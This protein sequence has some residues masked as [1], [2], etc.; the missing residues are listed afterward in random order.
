MILPRLASLNV[1]LAGLA[2]LAVGAATYAASGSPHAS[3]V[4][5]PLALLALNLVAA[6]A[7]NGVFRRDLPLMLFH[8]ALLAIVVLAGVGRL[9]HFQG[10]A[11]LAEG[12]VFEG[13][14]TVVESGPLH[15][16]ALD[17]VRFVNDGFTI[18]YAPGLKRAE[19][20]NTLR[21][22]DEAGGVTEQ[23]IGDNEPLQAHGYRFYTSFN[24]GFSLI[25]RWFPRAGAAAERG[26][27]NLPAYPA[28]EHRQALEWKL[29][30]NGP[31][32]WTELQF[33]KPPLDPDAQTTFRKPDT[34]RVVLRIGDGRWEI[35]PGQQV[36]LEDGV[37]AY[38]G[39]T[40]WMGY[41][42]FYDW[43]MP[44]LIAACFTAIAALGWHFARKFARTPW[45]AA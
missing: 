45:D 6:V 44:W 12:E 16:G 31:R 15:R 40:T 9:T 4:I 2:I 28:N 26:T 7:S 1:T 33:D 29:P 8:S 21:V 30:G 34:H 20:R 24:K 35:E 5:A 36:R 25:F 17:R 42:V 43:T 19:T 11:E 39:L 14:L 32:V 18:R 27:V 22:F 3:L 41:T 37:L 10:Q 23:V 38:E 13:Q